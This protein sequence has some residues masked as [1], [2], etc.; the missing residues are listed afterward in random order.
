MMFNFVRNVGFVTLNDME[1]ILR[2]GVEQ[3]V[4]L[5]SIYTRAEVKVIIL[6]LVRKAV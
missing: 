4:E 1:I 5:I 6:K 3:V 2:R